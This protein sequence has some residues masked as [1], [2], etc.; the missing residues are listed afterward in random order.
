MEKKISDMMALIQDDSV[1]IRIETI[2]SSERIKELTMA[3]LH[4]KK[5]RRM[6][7]ASRMVL[8]AAVA[9]MVL[10]ASALAVMTLNFGLKDMQG[11]SPDTISVNGHAGM[12]EYEAAV[13][14]QDDA[15]AAEE[16][17]LKTHEVVAEI[18]SLDDFFEAAGVDGFLP[19]VGDASEY[20]FR[21]EHPISGGYYDDG[22]FDLNCT[23]LM[24]DGKKI[25]YNINSQKRGTYANKVEIVGGPDDYEEWSYVTEDGTNVLLGIG[26]NRSLLAV[27]LEDCYVFILIR[28]GTV[29]DTREG[30]ETVD[31]SD[32]EAFAEG[33][34][35]AVINSLCK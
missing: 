33:F 20:D 9:V 19:E 13:N 2:A 17:G 22:S 15:G 16:Y 26:D 30:V 1:P 7:K 21:S 24:S 32:L 11:S 27:D 4:T 34:D 14:P 6:S 3:K 23:A 29:N 25:F 31:K 12:P 8:I 28:S 35:F 18:H 10:T 5:Y